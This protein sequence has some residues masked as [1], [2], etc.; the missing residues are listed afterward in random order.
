MLC[1]ITE[2][3]S[4]AFSALTNIQAVTAKLRVRAKSMPTL[5]LP[6]PYCAHSKSTRCWVSSIHPSLQHR[7]SVALKTFTALSVTPWS[8]LSPYSGVCFR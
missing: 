2:F 5:Q 1:S 6:R 3:P 4:S 7:P 8:R